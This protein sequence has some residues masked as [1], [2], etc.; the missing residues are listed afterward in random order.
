MNRPELDQEFKEKFTAQ[1][2]GVDVGTFYQSSITHVITEAYIR[3]MRYNPDSYLLL[4]SVSD[5]T[6]SEAI[7]VAKIV[8]QEPYMHTPDEG[9]WYMKYTVEGSRFRDLSC[10]DYLRSIGCALPFMGY[11][12][13]EL[14]AAGFVKI[15]EGGEE[16]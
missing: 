13:E 10:A 6:D 4:R 16:K 12:V 7:E 11:S 9:R 8:Y 3:V 14:V 15:K 2:W 5:L 1:Y